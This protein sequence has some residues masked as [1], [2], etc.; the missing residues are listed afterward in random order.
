MTT[1]ART[2][3]IF[4]FLTLG[5][6]GDSA[7]DATRM[8][9]V[10]HDG[11]S[12]VR[13]GD[14]K[15]ALIRA[16]PPGQHKVS[17]KKL[18]IQGLDGK[19]WKWDGDG[20]V[21]EAIL[22]NGR[23]RCLHAIYFGNGLEK[24]LARELQANKGKQIVRKGTGMTIYIQIAGEDVK[25]IHKSEGHVV[26]IAGTRDDLVITGDLPASWKRK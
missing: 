10:G 16:F 12:I 3:A 26:V 9:I 22:S 21:I 4:A 19:P 1:S 8:A 15:A 24:I 23:L 5:A 18:T 14:T 25:V 13:L 20:R 6:F 11:R 7:Y 17:E 2:L